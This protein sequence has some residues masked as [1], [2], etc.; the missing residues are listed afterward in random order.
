MSEPLR[1]LAHD[2]RGPA[3]T[4][5]GFAAEL[6]LA[7]TEL[8]RLAAE[9]GGSDGDADDGAELARAVAA[10]VATDLEP[11]LE[12]IASAATTLAE[13]IDGLD[14]AASEETRSA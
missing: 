11:C 14:G 12:C 7:V 10:I 8:S 6:R 13:R 1:R 3:L 5:Q 4:V 9:N 2:L